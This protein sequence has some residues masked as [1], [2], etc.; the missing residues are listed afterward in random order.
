MTFNTVIAFLFGTNFEIKK[1]FLRYMK[2]AM[3]IFVGKIHHC[4]II[5]ALVKFLFEIFLNFLNKIFFSAQYEFNKNSF[6]NFIYT[7]KNILI[8]IN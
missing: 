6:F 2:K 8:F 4:F 5:L 1:I 3:K 7:I